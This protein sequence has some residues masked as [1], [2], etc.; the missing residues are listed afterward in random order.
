MINP[1]PKPLPLL[2]NP[3]SSKSI[4]NVN[5]VDVDRC[6]LRTSIGLIAEENDEALVGLGFNVACRGAGSGVDVARV[7]GEWMARIGVTD[8]G[9]K[10]VV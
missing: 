1:L 9:D 3:R 8:M 6:P 7:F 4:I 2:C 5:A 10:T